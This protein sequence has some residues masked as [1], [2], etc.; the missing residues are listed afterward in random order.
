MGEGGSDRRELVR[1][2]RD[3]GR[4][5]GVTLGVDGMVGQEL[6]EI[7][8]PTHVGGLSICEMGRR[9]SVQREV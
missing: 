6:V 7:P 8:A 1:D 9:G 4:A 5:S 2:H 3:Q